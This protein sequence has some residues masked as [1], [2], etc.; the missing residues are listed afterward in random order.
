MSATH[1]NHV[2][3][4]QKSIKARSTAGA[5]LGALF[6]AVVA[7]FAC[8][9]VGNRGMDIG[10]DTDVY[11]GFFLAMDAGIPDTRLE[12]GFLYLTYILRQVGLGVTGY[13]AMLF[14]VLLG[15][16]V[17]ATRRYYDYLG[18]QRD[19]LTFL[20]AALF[21][22]FISPMFVNASINAVRQGLAAPLVFAS[23]L[24]FQRRKWRFFLLYGAMAASFHISALMYLA[25]APALLLSNKLLRVAAAAAFLAYVSG[26]SLIVVRAASPALYSTVMEYAASPIYQAGVRV[27]FAV[28]TIFWYALANLAAPL[29]RKQF[30]QQIVESTAVYLVMALPFFI[31][32]WGYFSNRYALP[33][34]MAASLI[35]AAILWHSRVPLLRNPVI[36]RLALLASCVVF[37]FYVKFAVVI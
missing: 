26:V 16:V 17:V 24:C 31:I 11:A 6:V 5:V 4:S 15:T 9:V 28:F 22:L 2:A 12:P 34:W 7:V 25:C 37:Y 19:Y 18:A 30:R 29:V 35:F 20:C 1:V 32:G 21:L 10:T 14:A 27:D 23:L 13:Q 36:L 33:A 8:W 3:A